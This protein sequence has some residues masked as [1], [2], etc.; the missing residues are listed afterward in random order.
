MRTFFQCGLIFLLLFAGVSLRAD[1]TL[2]WHTN[3]DL[4]SADIK[5]VELI[6]VL[7]GVA[8]LTGWHVFLESNAM[9]LNV[10]TKFKNVSSGEA[11]H[12]LFPN[13]NYALLPQT[14]GPSQL[15]VFR[16]SRSAA[17]QQVRPADLAAKKLAPKKIPNELIVRLK[18]G[19]NIDALAKKLGAKII[20]KIDSLNAYRLQFSDEAAADAARAELANNS[21]VAS[22]ENNYVVDAPPQPTALPSGA[23]APPINLKVNPAASSSDRTTVILVDTA[24]QKL[25]SDLDKFLAGSMSVAGTPNLDP[26]TPSHGTSM[27]ED[28]LRGAAAVSGGSSSVQ[29][30]NVDVYGPNATTSTFD[31]AA[32]LTAGINQYATTQSGGTG[33]TVVN[34]SLGSPAD[35]SLLHDVIQQA[36]QQGIVVY[37]AAG[38]N[39]S[40]DNFYPAAYPEVTS[41][42]ASYQG[43]LASYANYGSYVKLIA[44]GTTPVMYGDSTWLVSGTSSSS[45]LVSGITAGT[46]AS[47]N[48]TVGTAANG[49]SSSPTFQFKR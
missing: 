18:P 11:L 26:N 6:R 12:L 5:S 46:A 40:P 42:T 32:G 24:V 34:M 13:L 23:N 21:D 29:I 1:D 10:S 22:I 36:V 33:G 25:G 37:A 3:Q 41:V 8:K 27:F 44:P 31:V 9:S 39:S 28:I 47:R 7:E 2:V 4:V 45:A 38:N 15:Y 30:Y 14:N 19:A 20:G 43:A 49:V 48:I 16:T 17:T 35:S